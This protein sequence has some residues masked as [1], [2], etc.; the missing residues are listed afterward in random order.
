MRL[1]D[2]PDQ[3]DETS[4]VLWAVAQAP[5]VV[6]APQ[7]CVDVG[8]DRWRLVAEG[9]R[10]ARSLDQGTLV[11]AG[12]ALEHAVLALEAR[13]HRVEVELLPE[14][15]PAVVAC[16]TLAGRGPA[17]DLHADDAAGPPHDRV[18]PSDLR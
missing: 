9:Q 11:G 15:D 5:Q 3:L 13:H 7:W 12:S 18:T 16:L 4:Q 2:V 17:P 14:A 6:T 1:A 8:R 10:P